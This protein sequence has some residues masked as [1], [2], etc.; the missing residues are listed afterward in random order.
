[1]AYITTWFFIEF[2]PN[3]PY[4]IVP[5]VTLFVK[6]VLSLIALNE[7]LLDIVNDDHEFLPTPWQQYIP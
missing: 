4:P 1:M 3:D 6:I 2:T 5:V 7:T